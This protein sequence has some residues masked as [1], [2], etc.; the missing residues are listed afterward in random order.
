MGFGCSSQG[1][2]EEGNVFVNVCE[3]ELLG[4]RFRENGLLLDVNEEFYHGDPMELDAALSLVNQATVMSLVGNTL[5]AEAVKKGVVHKD[6]TLKVA[7]VS[8]AQVYNL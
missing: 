6:S 8:F 7:G 5:V 2:G 1:A 3:A 4:R